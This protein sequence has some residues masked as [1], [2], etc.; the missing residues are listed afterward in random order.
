MATN[1]PTSLDSLVNPIGTDSM[2]TVSHAGQHSN[3]ND[4]IEALEAK[5]GADGSAVTTSHDYKLGEVISTD[6]AVGKT[7]T[8]T[9]TNKT[10]TSPQINFGSDA[11]GDLI[12]RNGS[13][14]TTRLAIGTTDQILAVQSGL[15]TWVANPSA[16]NSSYS[17][18]GVVQ[19]L[20]DADTSGIT[21]ASGVANVNTGT[22][23]N[24]IVKL[25]ASAQ[26]P[27]VSGALLTNLPNPITYTNGTTTKDSA[28]ASTT[29]NIAHSLGIIP[30]K[31]KLFFIS[32]TTF[33]TNGGGMANVA[34]NGTTCSVVGYQ[35]VA[36]SN[37]SMNSSNN[38][39]LYSS[40][41]TSDYQQGVITFDSTNII[42]TWTKVFN[43]T[44]VFD[45][46]WE[47]E[48]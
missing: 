45:I 33:G 11:N 41:G 37:T 21:V 8:Q 12:Y 24:K 3:A 30:K 16:A 36:G 23:A 17:T 43:P 26:L 19:F 1:F 10:L 4:A 7:A 6:K 15:P 42:I 2:S 27:A 35:L 44:I 22:T 48:A 39:R 32:R 40:A 34:Y 25:N 9:L 47:A 31:I 18:K 20:T 29:Q 38:I 14:V 13:G 46:L 28:D 5:V